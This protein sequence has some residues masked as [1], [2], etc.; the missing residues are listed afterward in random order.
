MDNWKRNK[1]YN[2]FSN[3]GLSIKGRIESLDDGPVFPLTGLSRYA[4]TYRD[5]FSRYSTYF[6]EYLRHDIIAISLKI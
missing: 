3:W 1:L 6:L 2:T 5:L 4:N